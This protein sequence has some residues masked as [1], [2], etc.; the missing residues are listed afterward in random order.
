MTMKRLFKDQMRN[1]VGVMAGSAV[2]GTMSTMPG[3][4]ANAAALPMAGMNLVAVGGL[5]RTG[6][7]VAGM[8]GSKRRQRK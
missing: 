8:F 2:I 3:V 5:A 7:G 1:S 6:L 4:P